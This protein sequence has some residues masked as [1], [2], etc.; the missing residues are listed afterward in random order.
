MALEHGD[1]ELIVLNLPADTYTFLPRALLR[2]RAYGILCA[3]SQRH[4]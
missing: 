1:E 4:R 2:K 3:C